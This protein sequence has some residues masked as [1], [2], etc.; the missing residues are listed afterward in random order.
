MSGPRVILIG[1]PGAGKSTVG[2]ALAKRLGTDF[3][4]T[5]AWIVERAGKSIS[6]IVVDDGEP[7]FRAMEVTAVADALTVDDAVVALG[8]GAIVNPATRASLKSHRVV[9]LEVDAAEAARRV[10]MNGARPLLLTDARA[11]LVALM[12]E[13]APWYD[14][15]AST[16]ISTAGRGVDTIVDEIARWLADA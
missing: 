10:G 2:A 12:R 9:R 14:D 5:D 6:E 13:R 7:V 11:R 8:G 4:D 1:P 3:V 15:V 16:T